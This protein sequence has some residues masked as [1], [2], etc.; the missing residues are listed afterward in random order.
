MALNGRATQSSL[1]DHY[2]PSSA[3]DGNRDGVFTHGSCTHTKSD[4]SPWWRLDLLKR[5]KVFSVTIFNTADNIPER[6]KEA[7]I[8]IGD[9]LDDNGNKNPR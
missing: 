2:F 7:E 8:R 6:L 3:I 5:H 4:L 9:S 1:Y